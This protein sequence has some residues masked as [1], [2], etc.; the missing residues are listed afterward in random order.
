MN[1]PCRRI[2]PGGLLIAIVLSAISAAS[3]GE[4]YR[5]VIIP[6]NFTHRVDNPFFPLVPGAS[7]TFI[8]H[9]GRD[10]IEIRSL[11]TTN[12]RIVMGVTCAV[13]HETVYRNGTIEEDTYDWYA[14]DAQGAVWYFGEATREFK[15]GNRISTAGSWEA[16]VNNAQ[17]GIVMPAH[18]KVGERYRMEYAANEAEDIG[19]IAALGDTVSVPLGSF[20]DCV[21][22]REW[23]MLESGTST[24]WYARGIGLVRDKSATGEVAELTS[25]ST[26]E[27]PATY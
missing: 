25:I 11:V 12:S 1:L 2:V 20:A 6:A 17:P 8:E 26:N 3:A 10:K 21:R 5:S 14:Q 7:R 4:S 24:K 9:E 16:G 22:T 13:V 23:S 18:P 15:L 27:I 19:Q